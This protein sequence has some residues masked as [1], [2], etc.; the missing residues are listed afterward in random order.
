MLESP[1]EPKINIYNQPA[2]TLD[3][4]NQNGWGFNSLRDEALIPCDPPPPWPPAC[5]V[6]VTDGQGQSYSFEE[7]WEILQL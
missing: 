5:Q 4:Q 7:I 2:P 3:H 1:E 6:I